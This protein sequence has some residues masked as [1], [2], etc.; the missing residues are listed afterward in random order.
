MATTEQSSSTYGKTVPETGNGGAAFAER[1]PPTN[2][3]RVD[4]FL[5]LLLLA[6]S[7]SAI[8]V[9]VTSKQSSDIRTGLPPPFAVVS[10]AAK[11]QHVPAFIYLL[12][13]LCVSSL[14]SIVTMFASF[15]SISS[16]SPSTRILFLLTVCD[17][18][19]DGRSDGVG[20]GERRVDW[21]PGAVG[22]LARQLGKDLQQLRQ[23]LPICR[24]LRHQSHLTLISTKDLE[25]STF[26]ARWT[27]ICRDMYLRRTV[28]G[29]AIDKNVGKKPSWKATTLRFFFPVNAAAAA[30]L[31]VDRSASLTIGTL[32]ISVKLRLCSLSS[33]LKSS[34]FPSDSSDSL[35]SPLGKR[36]SGVAMA[37]TEQSSSTYGKTGPETGNGGAAFA[38][39][40]PPTNLF[41][42]DFLL[43]LLLLA[44]SVSALVVLVTSNQS[45]DFRT[46]L[47]P[48]LAVVSRAAKFQ[49]VP[50]FIYLLA[51]LC[52]SSLYSFV[53]MFASFFS[54]SSPSPST[55][56]LFL[57]ILCDAL[58]AGVMASAMGSAGSIAYLGLRGNSHAN[59][60]KICNT[61]GKFC[62]HVGSSVG[63]SLFATVV[64]VQLVV[65]SSYSLYRRTL[66][67]LF[68]N[69]GRSERLRKGEGDPSNVFRWMDVYAVVCIAGEPRFVQRTPIDKN[70]GKKTSWDAAFGIASDC[71]HPRPGAP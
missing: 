29:T 61:Y 52:V 10:R 32:A 42:V 30:D 41:R 39:R 43:R 60:L 62:R 63:V 20:D 35:I 3:F 24:Q 25:M 28:K 57:L 55:R 50:A 71:L 4:F 6:S 70:T 1:R 69:L 59:W 12:A 7:V 27:L 11:F 33:Y 26:S 68:S 36:K 22:E 23:V 5:R 40:R 15:F 45:R 48:P 58:M 2:L 51:A 64:L 13:A 49:H 66:S 17:V 9:L 46:G 67:R 14:Y 31:V 38:H 34:P 21:V 16:P 18:V 53:T 19:I 37:T 56:I 44:S 54:I 65:L 8:A 47:P